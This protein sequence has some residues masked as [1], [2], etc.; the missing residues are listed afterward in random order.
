LNWIKEFALKKN[1][2]V[3]EISLEF[4]KG[5]ESYLKRDIKYF[6]FDVVEATQEKESVKPLIY[7]FDSNFLYYPLL[8]SGISEI[9][10]SRPEINI[11]IITK[12]EVPT[13]INR[14][15]KSPLTF[16]SYNWE[17][18]ASGEI[19]YRSLPTI[20]TPEIE[21]TFEEIKEVSEEIAKLF[22]SGV[23]VRKISYTGDLNRLRKDLMV[24][25]S[26]YWKIP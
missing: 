6:V 20:E 2:S 25:P 7:R 10:E 5:I 3:K 11:F 26:H 4:K 9:S 1:L 8:I 13:I 19:S 24:Y 12:N 18:L 14:I 15:P 21:L 23:K 22:H 16:F 17:E